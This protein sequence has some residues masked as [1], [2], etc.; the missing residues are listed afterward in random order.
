MSKIKI[1]PE[2]LSNKIAAGEVVER[3]ASVVKELVEN[4]LDAKSTRIRIE[5]E[6]GGRSSI[7]VSD[8]GVGM[9]RDDAML[10]IER[11]ATSKIYKD[12]DLFSIKTL[13]FRGEALPSI[14]AVSRF[15]LVTREKTTDYGTAIYVEGG[16][17]KKVAE[18]GAPPGTMITVTQIFFNTPARRKFLKTINTETGHIA[19]TV[20]SMALG[21]PSV[22][23]QLHHNGKPVKGWSATSDPAVRVSEVLGKDIKGQLYPVQAEFEGHTVRGWVCDPRI[24]RH[25]SRGTYTYINGR[26]VRDRV[27][28]HALF[29][30]Y[31]GRLMK[32]QYPLAVLFISVPY[33]QVDV[34][35]HPTKSQVRFVEQNKIHA[36]VKAA[37]SKALKTG[38]N[39]VWPAISKPTEQ[40]G[41]G[42]RRAQKVSESRFDYHPLGSEF[43][44]PGSEFRVPG[45]EFRVPGSEF[46]VPGSE[47]RVPNSGARGQVTETPAVRSE[48][49]PHE[50]EDGFQIENRKSKIENQTALW[51]KRPFGD[52][53]IIGQL[54]QAYIVCESNEG[55][56][57]VDQHAA[58]ERI[59]FEQLKASSNRTVK[60]AQRLVISETV[61]L[62]YT[63]ADILKK[64]NPSL[65]E[66]GLDIEPFGGNTFVVKAIPALLEG[67]NIPSM[68]IEMVEQIAELGLIHDLKKAIEQCL[69]VMACHETIRANQ[70]LSEKEMKTLLQQLDACDTPS[71]CPHGRPVWIDWSL[72]SLEKSF[73][74]IV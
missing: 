70:T 46:R 68:I 17:L 42:H 61:D 71:H 59:R 58:H 52:L 33:D 44:V 38:D 34:N 21:W 65:S 2:I 69:I 19:D 50:V 43:R 32:G 55:L 10:A 5:I 28:Q 67:K 51:E 31:S 4:A 74:R 41:F 64:L 49:M 30:G 37:V 24:I 54:H 25:T 56:V 15:S 47:F 13:G 60:E 22:Q 16:K 29:E 62:S 18:T 3:P 73:R 40:N 72:R 8:N 39:P 48:Q 35:V 63:E 45:S 26:F 27:V 12:T 66:F 57:L 6:Q 11:Y 36:L 9:S 14:A 23:F 7:R 53:K 1:L 20:S